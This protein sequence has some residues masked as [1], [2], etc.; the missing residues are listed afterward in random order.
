MDINEAS[1]KLGVSVR[2]IQKM[3]ATGRIQGVKR[4]NKWSFTEEEIE[5]VKSERE[6]EVYSAAMIRREHEAVEHRAIPV[7][8]SVLN[9]PLAFDAMKDWQRAQVMTI[10]ERKLFLTLDEA[11]IYSGFGVGFI[12]RAIEEGKLSAI[13]GAGYRG[14][15]IIRRED[16]ETFAANLGKGRAR[17]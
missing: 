13:P 11:A 1:E 8:P 10:L 4:F 14:S 3:L 7:T 9:D 17:K 16:L 6:R 5:R 2:S 15:T 12:R